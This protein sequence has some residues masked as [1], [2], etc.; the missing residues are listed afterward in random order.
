MK[1]DILVGEFIGEVKL[2]KNGFKQLYTWLEGR[3]I[4]FAKADR[5][6]YLTIMRLE[7]FIKIYGGDA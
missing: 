5:R 7:T 4:L 1:G 2:R 6:E 3:D